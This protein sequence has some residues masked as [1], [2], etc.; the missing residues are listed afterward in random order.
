MTQSSQG[1]SKSG[2]RRTSSCRAREKFTSREG[3]VP[4][5]RRHCHELKLRRVLVLTEKETDHTR[6]AA[7]ASN[8]QPFKAQP[9]SSGPRI[10]DLDI[11]SV[12]RCLG[13]G[14]LRANYGLAFWR[15][16]A[17]GF[18][19]RLYSDTGTW[20]DYSRNR[21]GG[22]L[23][24]VE[25]AFGC[26]RR[27]ALEWLAVNFGI[28]AGNTYSAAERREFAERREMARA[29]AAALVTRRDTAIAS[30]QARERKHLDRFHSLQTAA[31]EHED[32]ELLA[33]ADEEFLLVEVLT[34]RRD[35][36]AAA[37]GVTLAR[38]LSTE[39]TS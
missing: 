5:T 35:E 27:A 19:V 14:P 18:N 22:I 17:D 13:G 25:I 36:L 9:T 20:Y 15:L 26:D 28:G 37:D 10:S 2:S 1:L 23:A 38:L 4:K 3:Q 12:W 30:I 11:T 33:E 8:S 7:G 21:G 6:I 29:A 31:Y 32:I 34:V 16:D 39:V 24:L